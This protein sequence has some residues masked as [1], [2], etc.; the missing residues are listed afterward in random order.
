[1]FATSVE[2]IFCIYIQVQKRKKQEDDTILYQSIVVVGFFK[3]EKGQ[4]KSF[5]IPD[6][7]YVW[8]DFLK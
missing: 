5:L 1:M 8:E 2:H 4:A 6:G 7:G 3:P